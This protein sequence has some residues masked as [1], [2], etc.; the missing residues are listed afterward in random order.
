MND[1]TK[2]YLE[3]IEVAIKNIED[4]LG[5]KRDFERYTQNLMLKHAVERN[6]EIIGEAV[7][8]ALKRS[9]DLSLSYAR[10]IVDLRNKLIHAYDSIDDAIIWSII[11][12]QLPLLKEEV[13]QL[14]SSQADV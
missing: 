12:Q 14:L 7:N 10:R 3:D 9:P 13:K 11:V 2:K 1:Q 4:F 5:E 8:H 6:L